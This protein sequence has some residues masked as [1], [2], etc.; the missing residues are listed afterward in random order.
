MT[1]PEELLADYVDGTLSGSLRTSV[2]AHLQT[3]PRCRAEVELADAGRLA[4]ARLPD[5]RSP[6]LAGRVI[7][8]MRTGVRGS[9]PPAAPPWFRYGGVAAAAVI[10][11]LI[12]VVLPKVGTDGASD[13]AASSADATQP[14]V[15]GTETLAALGLELQKIDYDEVAIQTLASGYARSTASSASGAIATSG[16]LGTP[17]QT[18]RAQGC[19]ASAFPGFPGS[20]IRLLAARFRGTPAYLAVVLEGPG[21][22]QSADTVTVW[23]VDR[24]TCDALSF[25]TTRI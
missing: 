24:A 12:A 5:P 9:A 19:V 20:P 22:G 3:C 7:A 16:P 2:D 4:L 10:V 21:P 13:R 15:A 6:D 8:V 11:L 17:A 23:V 25:T 14:T 1:H 18:A